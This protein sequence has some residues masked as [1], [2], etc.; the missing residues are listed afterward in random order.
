MPYY[1]APA[2]AA[3]CGRA[4]GRG[5]EE[6]RGEAGARASRGLVHAR[7]GEAVSARERALHRAPNEGAGPAVTAH[8]E[9]AVC[10]RQAA[11]AQT[12]SQAAAPGSESL[13]AWWLIQ[14]DRPL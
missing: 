2:A 9:K 11:Q 8:V 5:E 14:A 10:Q 3:G 13:E 12:P 6:G 1:R 7:A 4:L